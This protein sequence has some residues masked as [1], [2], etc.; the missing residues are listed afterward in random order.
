MTLI[1]ELPANKAS[2]SGEAIASSPPQP[3]VSMNQE[4]SSQDQIK[5]LMDENTAL[6][7]QLLATQKE[8]AETKAALATAQAALA[9][10][11]TAPPAP[12]TVLA[13][14]PQSPVSPP[15][16]AEAVYECAI[17]RTNVQQAAQRVLLINHLFCKKCAGELR[18]NIVIG[19]SITNLS[20][21]QN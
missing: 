1:F 2:V 16:A 5:T 10:Y 13:Q 6:L 19:M 20:A 8:L 3:T 12:I 9:Q 18:Q 14:P 11:Q 17:C 7:A 21:P 15:R 4:R